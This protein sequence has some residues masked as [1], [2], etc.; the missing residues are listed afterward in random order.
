M[1]TSEK[2][3]FEEIKGTTNE[4]I[5]QIKRLFKEGNAR[6]LV[7]LNKDDKILFQS[8]LTIG[9]AGTAFAAAVAPLISAILAFLLFV[10]DARVLVEKDPD[11]DEARD[12][13]EIDAEVIDI[14]DDD[15]DGEDTAGTSEP[16][17]DKKK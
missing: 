10:N 17:P 1:T 15:E 4:I 8:Q 3:V 11:A 6:R 9:I 14:S 2:S 7:I 13:N 16:E 12:V 5:S